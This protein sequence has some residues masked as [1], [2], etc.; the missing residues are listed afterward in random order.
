MMQLQSYALGEWVA[1]TGKSAE[2]VNAVTGEVIGEASSGGLD[3]GA[4]AA[5]A[6]AT[7]GPALRKMTFHER[8]LMLKA[9]AKY[10]MER[11]EEFYAVSAATG[12]TRTDSWIDIRRQHRH[13]LSYF[14]RSRPPRPAE[15]NVFRGWRDRSAVEARHVRPGRHIY[16]QRSRASRSTSNASTTSRAGNARGSLRPRSSQAVPAIVKPTTV[17]SYLTESMVRAMID[18]KLLPAGALQLIC[19][20]AGDLLSHLGLQDTVA[21]T[22]SAATWADAEGEP[23][24]PRECRALQHGSRFA[25]TVRSSVPTPRPARRDS[26]SS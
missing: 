10:L 12:A 2:L 20:S 11:K 7:G 22:G 23:R 18:S 24:D 16:V 26:I 14:R 1:G 15:R 4:M 21:F 8:A 9:L 13:A 5:Y 25:P 6:R 17:T 19:G 3:F